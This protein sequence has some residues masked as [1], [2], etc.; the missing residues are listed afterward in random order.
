MEQNGCELSPG[1]K[2]PAPAGDD[3]QLVSHVCVRSAIE[4]AV[5]ESQSVVNRTGG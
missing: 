3:L 1:V 4:L 5:A 2:P